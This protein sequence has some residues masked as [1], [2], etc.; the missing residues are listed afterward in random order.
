MGGPGKGLIQ[1]K[2]GRSDESEDDDDSVSKKPKKVETE[3]QKSVANAGTLL[4]AI[5][6]DKNKDFCQLM[7][8]ARI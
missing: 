6:R 4:N 2:R 8:Q 7:D 1:E 3:V 5:R